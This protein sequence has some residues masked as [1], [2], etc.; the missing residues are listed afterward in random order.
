[1]L[2]NIDQCMPSGQNDLRPARHQVHIIDQHP[3]SFKSVHHCIAQVTLQNIFQ[4]TKTG[5]QDIILNNTLA[6]INQKAT[7]IYS[8]RTA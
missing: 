8:V 7:L 6:R 1:M 4:C 5:Y 2:G 3:F